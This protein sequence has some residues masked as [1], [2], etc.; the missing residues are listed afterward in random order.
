MKI[1]HLVDK[2]DPKRGGVCQAVRTIIKG[3]SDPG[4]SHEV[5]SLDAPDSIF[6]KSDLFTQYA[7]GPTNNPWSYNPRLLPFLTD[8]LTKFDFII[9]HG[10]W[11]YHTYAAYKAIKLLRRRIKTTELENSDL[12]KL[13]VMPHGMLDPYFQNAPER[14]LKAIRNNLYWKFIENKVVNGA[15]GL[16]FTC[17]TERILARETFVPYHPKK[18]IIVGLG[19]VAPP[20]YDKGMTDEFLKFC[21]PVQHKP[22]LLFLSR[23]H[24]KKGVDLLIKAYRKI[25]H[26]DPDNRQTKLVIAGPGLETP[27]GK[28]RM[29]L[30][31][32]DDLLQKNVFFPGMLTGAAKWGAF[33]GCEAFILPSH[34]ENF[35]IAVIE[36]MACGKPVLISD[37]INIFREIVRSGGAIVESDT[38][39]GTLA[40]LERWYSLDDDTKKEMGRNAKKCFGDFFAIDRMLKNW[41]PAIFQS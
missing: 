29:Q 21:L 7:I 10:L 16:L 17:D 26:E 5:L 18:E 38:T 11:Q 3:V 1:L 2:M 39:R 8:N 9:L 12:P 19:E 20:K 30:V 6:L 32:Q 4:I 13:L 22:Y 37:Q 25:I 14:K 15:D 23:I 35:G 36:A 33:Y 28:K 40:L 41:M 27:F 34:Q 31:S 24:E